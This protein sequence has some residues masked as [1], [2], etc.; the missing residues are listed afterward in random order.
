[1]NLSSKL[2]ALKK[3]QAAK[4]A[5]ANPA[6]HQGGESPLWRWAWAL[7]G[8]LVAGAGTLAVF[9]FF[10]WNKIPPALVGKWQVEEGP[11]G[12]GTF[13]FS[14]N[15]TL[16]VQLKNQKSD[17]NLKAKAVVKGKTLVTT[18]TNP[19]TQQEQIRTST[20]RELT[21]HSLILEFESGD[22]LRMA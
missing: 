5:K 9:E 18:S 16:L 3:Q 19:L 1:M 6:R 15:G 14:R 4:R 13:A 22:I 7:M 8:L 10:V 12:T 21:A 11:E 20:I 17:Y 2:A